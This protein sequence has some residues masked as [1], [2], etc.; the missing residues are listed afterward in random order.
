MYLWWSLCT[1][2][3]LYLHTCRVRVNVDDSGLCCCACVTYFESLL[4]PLNV[5][6]FLTWFLALF[7]NIFILK[8]GKTAMVV[9][10]H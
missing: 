10:A 8:V 5:E 7:V 1:L 3:R 6:F 2:L 9:C 4:P